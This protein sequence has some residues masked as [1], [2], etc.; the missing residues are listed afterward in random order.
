MRVL[1]LVLLAGAVLLIA[2]LD[3]HTLSVRRKASRDVR[4]RRNGNRLLAPLA[5]HPLNP[6]PLPETSSE[7]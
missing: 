2:N 3:R 7:M 6:C 4:A 1:A 5:V